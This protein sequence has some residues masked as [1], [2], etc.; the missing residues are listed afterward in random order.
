MMS[1]PK[2]LL[3]Y[4]VLSLWTAP[5]ILAQRGKCTVT[6]TAPKDVRDGTT[7]YLQKTDE[8]LHTLLT[9]QKTTVR[10][11]QYTFR[12][13]DIDH[14]SLRFVTLMEPACQK[15]L[16]IME[17]GNVTLDF[18]SI[19][20]PTGTALNN[21]YRDFCIRMRETDRQLADACS[22]SMP[23]TQKTPCSDLANMKNE[24]WFAYIK[25]N[26]GNEAGM[27]LLANHADIFTAGQRLALLSLIPGEYREFATFRQMKAR[28]DAFEATQPGTHF[29]DAKAFGMDEQAVSLSDYAEK[30][31]Y[32]LVDFWASW[33][34]PCIG[35]MP[36]LKEIYG[37]YKGRGL[38]I[39]GVSLDNHKTAWLSAIEKLQP[40]WP[41]MGDSKGWDSEIAQTYGINALPHTVLIAPDGLIIERGLTGDAIIKKMELLMGKD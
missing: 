29:T 10:K 8:D 39:V 33:C 2:F 34:V 41:Q 19:A 11:R 31:K 4:C 20:L 23:T 40:D 30:G 26:I 28:T 32:L 36:A 38:E 14:P 12:N 25:S 18:D 16:V 35:E 6:G 17:P 37:K 27:Y 5:D 15:A 22:D 7:V 13:Q 1:L 9:V 24:Q 3:L 21:Q